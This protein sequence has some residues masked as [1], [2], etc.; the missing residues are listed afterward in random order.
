MLKLNAICEQ[1]PSAAETVYLNGG[2][3]VGVG[4]S[5][6][7]NVEVGE[8]EGVGVSVGV[9]VSAVEKLSGS[10]GTRK[11]VSPAATA[12]TARSE[13]MAAGRLSVNCGMLAA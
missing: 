6:A 4:V 10:L 7:G 1:E 8:S 3:K 13:P 11:N 9:E 2:C 5:V 12:I